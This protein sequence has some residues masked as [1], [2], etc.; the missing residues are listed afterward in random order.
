MAARKPAARPKTGKTMRVDACVV[1]SEDL[2]ARGGTALVAFPGQGLASTLATAYL[3]EALDLRTV[4]RLDCSTVPALAVVEAGTVIHPIRVLFGLDGRTKAKA[5]P[6]V[7][8]LSEVALDEPNLR[9]VAATILA[10]CKANG[11]R[12]IIT[13]EGAAF[14][15]PEGEPSAVQL[16]G[17]SN[18]EAT[19]KR[20]AAA[21]L[22]MA[23]EGVIG[24]LT[25]ALLDQGLD[26]DLEI[27]ALVA[28][29]GGLEPDVRA[30]S[31][32]VEFLAKFLG[33]PVALGPLRRETERFEKH[34]K[35]I[36]RRRK[37]GQ[38]EGRADPQ[39]FI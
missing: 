5:H 6:L 31:R 1:Q 30:A 35:D 2:D 12:S 21:K 22:A 32:L 8:F 3:A 23:K 13:M 7:A 17:V 16:W 37:A 18:N 9:P 33:L 4:G 36:E 25:G 24:G 29:G 14:D 34:L 10:W 19:N 39:E 27:I 26:E 11:I 28:V 20:L 15:D 38:P